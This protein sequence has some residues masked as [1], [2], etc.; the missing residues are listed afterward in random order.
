VGTTGLPID[1][2][3]NNGFFDLTLCAREALRR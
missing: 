3:G 1:E 2:D